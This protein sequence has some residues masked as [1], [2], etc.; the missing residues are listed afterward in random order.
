MFDLKGRV[1][2]VT[3]VSSGL[4]V[5]MAKALGVDCIYVVCSVSDA[6][7]VESAT[8]KV[9]IVINNAGSGGNEPIEEISDDNW[10]H[11][12]NVDLTGVCKV[13]IKNSY[14]RIINIASMY[15]MFIMWHYLLRDT[16]QQKVE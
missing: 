9:D 11:V 10:E 15:G 13:M 2:V 6:D 4:G 14:G 16:M 12:I 5:R 8:K 7:S 3:G 1:T